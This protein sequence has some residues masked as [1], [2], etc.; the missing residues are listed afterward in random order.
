MR[1]ALRQLRQN[2]GFTAL[3]V[4]TLALGIGTNT[5]IFSF[6][7]RVF[8]RQLP[9]RKPQELVT[10]RFQSSTGY[11]GD[12]CVYP[13]YRALREQAQSVFSGLIAY[14]LTPAVLGEGEAA[15][16]VPVMAVSGD[17]FAVLGVSPVVGRGFL[18]EEDRNPGAQPVAVLSYELWRQQFNGDPTVVGRMI[19][20]NEHS[21]S[22]V[23]VAPAQFA[24]TYA[25]MN[26]AVYLPLGTWAG[27]KGIS[28]QKWEY[29]WLN[30][31]GRLKSGADRQQ[32]Q[33]TLQILAERLRAVEPMNAPA[34]IIVSDG[35]R[36]TNIW[37]EEGLWWPFALVQAATALVLLIACAN[38]T[39]L[40][41]ARGLS[42]QKEIAVRVAMGA[43]RTHVLGQLLLESL[44]L[45]L[46]GGGFGVLFSQW[47]SGVLRNSLPLAHA[48]NIPVT[49]DGRILVFGL[50]S[51]LA[52]ALVCGLAPALR[53]SRPNLVSALNEGSGFPTPFIR[54]WS[55]RN[56]MVVVQVAMT[57]ILLALGALCLR[58]LEKLKVA[59]PGF[60]TDGIVTASVDRKHGVPSHCEP[61]L[62]FAD[63]KERVAG[64][65]RV[66]AVALAGSIPLTMEGRNKTLVR[67]IEGFQMPP[68]PPD[69]EGLSLDI[70][71]VGPG[72]YRTL[73]IPLLRGRD[74]D[75]QDGPGSPRVMIVNELFAERF[76]PEQEPIGKRVV[77]DKEAREVIG[78]VRTVKLKS[79]QTE[80]FPLMFC[81]INQPMDGQQA[82]DI[83][84]VL[85]VRAVGDPK[86]IVRVVRHEMESAGLGPAACDVRLLRERMS[87]LYTPQRLIAGILNWIGLA[88]LVF[89]VT[90][91]FGVMAY[92]VGQRTREIGIRAA[93]GARWTDIRNLILRKGMVLTGI[94]LGLGACLSLVPLC[95]LFTFIPELR[96]SDDFFFYGVRAWDP[97]PYAVVSLFVVVAALAACWIP[98]RRAAR[99]APMTA[100]RCE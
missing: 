12:T 20:I 33:A 7:D 85:L 98:A 43:K 29:D 16:E 82:A 21:L 64:F 40:L 54:R 57:M 79:I 56:L 14:W 92:E 58:S 31:L 55:L 52:T 88:G 73:G 35:S 8:L 63:L 38:V 45:A 80:P 36:G 50:L 49:V 41:L 71:T 59:D 65:P 95:L 19:R 9:V 25:G 3:V 11:R 93:L 22:V 61:H 94:G 42:R 99:L 81:P 68:M 72:Y 18:T 70:S 28:L 91:I 34:E 62:L 96:Q 51:S 6:L 37:T 89:A 67:Q 30:L 1:F 69:Q 4:L 5:A 60:D 90:G 78:V 83:A 44:L 77:F 84:P 10:L 17:Y 39:N 46:L 24:G 53:V 2:P 97:V 47:L 27:I 100:L 74:F 26:P 76:W 48:A 66:E 15:H 32:A 23:G 86:A 13:V 75:P 87:D